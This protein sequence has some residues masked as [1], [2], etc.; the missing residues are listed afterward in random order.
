MKNKQLGKYLNTYNALVSKTL[1][2]I[3]CSASC[4]KLNKT[5]FTRFIFLVS[6]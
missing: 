1:Y 5:Q 6:I 3:Q 4:K 2:V